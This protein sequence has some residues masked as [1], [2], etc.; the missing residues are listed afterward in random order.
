MSFYVK[1]VKIGKGLHRPDGYVGWTGPIRTQAQAEREAEAW[2]T[3]EG[4]LGDRWQAGVVESTPEVKAA[5]R[6]WSRAAV[7][8]ARRL[9]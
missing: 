9:R 7:A 4:S 3:A 2:N 1:R 6:A 8:K 5:V